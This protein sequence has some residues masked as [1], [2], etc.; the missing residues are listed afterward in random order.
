VAVKR[1]LEALQGRNS[2]RGAKGLNFSH[3]GQYTGQSWR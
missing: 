3:L 1:Q 2:G